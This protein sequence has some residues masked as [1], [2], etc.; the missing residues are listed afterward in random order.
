MK[1]PLTFP[2]KARY[3]SIYQLYMKC[4]LRNCF[5]HFMNSQTYMA[6]YIGQLTTA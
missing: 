2:L 6:S 5:W 4:C 1:A 3:K